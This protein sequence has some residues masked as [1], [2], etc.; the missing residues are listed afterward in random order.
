[1]GGAPPSMYV[2][3]LPAVGSPASVSTTTYCEQ[4]Y[5]VS[6]SDL[7][8]CLLAVCT[9][10]PPSLHLCQ[11]L[12]FYRINSASHLPTAAPTR[13]MGKSGG[14]ALV[15]ST[16]CQKIGHEIKSHLSSLGILRWLMPKH[17]KNAEIWQYNMDSYR[18]VIAKFR[19]CIIAWFHLW[20][21]IMQHLHWGRDIKHLDRICYSQEV[22]NTVTELKNS[23]LY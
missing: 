22:K 18:C 2:T 8:Q 23:S 17:N 16:L 9:S 21:T 13:A 12:E 7:L 19:I 11:Y 14:E 4:N 1:M 6:E 5:Q 10:S 20:E 3:S 15:N